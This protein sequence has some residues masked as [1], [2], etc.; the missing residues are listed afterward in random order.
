[1]NHRLGPITLSQNAD[2]RFISQLE[3]EDSDQY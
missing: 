2:K 1:M 3:G